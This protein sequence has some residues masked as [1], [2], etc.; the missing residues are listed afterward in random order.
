MHSAGGICVKPHSRARSAPETL[1]HDRHPTGPS[2]TAAAGPA[3]KRGAFRLGIRPLAAP[4]AFSTSSKRR[5]L[6]LD[7]C[8]FRP[9]VLRGGPAAPPA[10][11][12]PRPRHGPGS[13]RTCH[14]RAGTVR[15]PR[16]SP[17]V[18]A[19]FVATPRQA[20]ASRTRASASRTSG[21]SASA[22]AT[23][24]SSA[25]SCSRDRRAGFVPLRRSRRDRHLVVRPDRPAA[26][27]QGERH[28]RRQRGAPDDGAREEQG[29]G[30]VQASSPA[31]AIGPTV[32]GAS[33]RDRCSAGACCAAM[34]E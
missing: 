6:P 31:G 24:R 14:P 22:W 15:S 4:T 3:A 33:S 17:T 29:N 28:Q 1:S 18:G 11:V 32:A 21:P 8:L 16:P 26:G 27:Q 2:V 19:R 34:S 25:G 30:G 7:P 23:S 13:P 5:A 20:R 12:E 9:R 10:P